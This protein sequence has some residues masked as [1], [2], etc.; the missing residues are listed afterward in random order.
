[1]TKKLVDEIN[2]RGLA[3]GWHAE[4]LASNAKRLGETMAD[5]FKRK[6]A[7]SSAFSVP[8]TCIKVTATKIYYQF[9]DGSKADFPNQRKDQS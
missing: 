7:N 5:L 9:N 2:S 1:M 6:V 3:R 8:A 4:Q